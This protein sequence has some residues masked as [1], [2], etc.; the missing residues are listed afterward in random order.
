MQQTGIFPARLQL[1]RLEPTTGVEIEREGFELLRKVY[2]PGACKVVRRLAEIAAERLWAESG[3]GPGVRRSDPGPTAEQ[4]LA[5]RR[6]AATELSAADL[7]HL[8][9]FHGYEREELEEH[10]YLRPMPDRG[11]AAEVRCLDKQPTLDDT[12][13]LLALARAVAHSV[14][15]EGL[16]PAPEDLPG[17]FSE[18]RRRGVGDP[19][20]VRAWLERMIRHLPREERSYLQPLF[21]S[22]ELG[23]PAARARVQV[24]RDGL[25]GYL[26]ALCR[27]G[28]ARPDRRVFA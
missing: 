23:T 27:R 16:P 7:M 13:A 11:V 24:T 6:Q 17:R 9:V 22:L 25:H 15:A 8:P 2:R 1:G 14:D 5:D 21:R 12:F 18:A 19:A 28:S 4:R 26:A 3:A 20:E 10:K